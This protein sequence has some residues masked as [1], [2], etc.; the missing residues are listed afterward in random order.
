MFESRDF[1]GYFQDRE[2]VGDR[3]YPWRFRVTGFGF[4]DVSCDV[5]KTDGSIERVPIT[6]E[7]CILIKGQ[8][9]DHRYWDH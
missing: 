7:N 2:V 6:D 3:V 5:L 1:N 4:D 9:Y 8:Y